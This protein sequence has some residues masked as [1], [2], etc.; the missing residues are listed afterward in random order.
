M[1]VDL[2]KLSGVVL[3]ITP[4][5]LGQTVSTAPRPSRSLQELS[6]SFEGLASRVRPAVVQIFSTG[7]TAAEDTEGTSASSLLSKQRVTGSGVIVSPDGYI[8]TNNH[9]VNKALKIEVK[10]VR[11]ERMNAA[12]STV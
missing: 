12:D 5:L 4:F 2:Q 8:I 7:Y 1:G 11:G 6:S 3:G 9:V 10:L